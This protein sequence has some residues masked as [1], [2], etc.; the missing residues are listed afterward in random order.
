MFVKSCV[1]RNEDEAHQ[2][3]KSVT[4]CADVFLIDK[5]DRHKTV[6]THDWLLW[7][8]KLGRRDMTKSVAGADTND[9]T[10]PTLPAGSPLFGLSLPWQSYVVASY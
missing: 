9:T 1:N 8:R 2:F 5:E 6:T 4:E 7:C 10:L 3:S